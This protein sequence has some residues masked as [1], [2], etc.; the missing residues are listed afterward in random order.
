MKMTTENFCKNI[1]TLREKQGMKQQDAADALGVTLKTYQ[2]YEYGITS[3]PDERKDDLA[4]IF[5]VKVSDLYRDSLT[6]SFE[7]DSNAKAELLTS[8]YSIAPTLSEEELRKVVELA[9]SFH[10]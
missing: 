7:L 3:P 1:K 2:R 6:S 9:S 5:G 8:L 10:T 4:K